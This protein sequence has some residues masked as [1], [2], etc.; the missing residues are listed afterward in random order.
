MKYLYNEGVTVREESSQIN[1]ILQFKL[2]AAILSAVYNVIQQSWYVL[3][4]YF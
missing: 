2:L 4:S 1:V 3:L